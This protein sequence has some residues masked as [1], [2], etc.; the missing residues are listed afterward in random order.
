MPTYQFRCPDC[1]ELFEE[2]RGFAQSGEPA[3]CPACRSDRA[4]KVIGAAMFFSKGDAARALLE[5]KPA[6][7]AAVPTSHG[8]DCPCCSGRLAR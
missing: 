8:A 7:R 6:K 4:V 3:V 1:S 2:K 5:P